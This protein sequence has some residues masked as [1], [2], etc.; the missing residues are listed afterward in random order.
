MKS[1]TLE[2][3]AWADSLKRYADTADVYNDGSWGYEYEDKKEGYKVGCIAKV[4]DCLELFT[5]FKDKNGNKIYA[6]SDILDST[7]F[8]D[9]SPCPYTITFIDG[10]YRKKIFSNPD[11]LLSPLSQADINLLED[12]I[13][14][15]IHDKENI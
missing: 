5:G 11:I 13:V 8:P 15:N 2:F 1:N 6:D 12:E 14:G 9:D 4:N 7:K 3:R 10:S